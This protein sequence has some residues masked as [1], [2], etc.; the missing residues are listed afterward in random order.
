MS[1]WL[2]GWVGGGCVGGVGVGETHSTESTGPV[3]Y[4]MCH[5]LAHGLCTCDSWTYVCNLPTDLF[6]PF[7]LKQLL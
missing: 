6:W 1:G 4:N 5:T 7:Q 3:V 2:S